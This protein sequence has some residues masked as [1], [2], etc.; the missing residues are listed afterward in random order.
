MNDSFGVVVVAA[1]RGSRMG[2]P[3]SKQFLTVGGL[4]ILVHTLKVFESIPEAADIVLVTGAADVDRCRDYVREYSLTKVKA[5]LAG[6]AERQISVRLGLAALP[7]ETDWVLVHDGVRPFVQ[8]PEIL[9]CW[10]EAQLTGGAVLAVPVKDTIKV[11]DSSGMIQ[12]SPERRSLWA[13]QTPQA[14]RFSLL[15]EAHERALR[16][17]FLGTDDVSLLERIGAPVRVV[18]GRYDNIK[19]TTPEDLKWAEA[20]LAD[21]QEG[22][23]T[24]ES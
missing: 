8:A 3:E 13:M 16:D 5:V 1:G 14:F 4:P 7:E 17:G 2:T 15:R 9:A 23:G 18:E 19:I 10:R 20:F 24:G 21:S 22:E 11:V 6:G 12:H